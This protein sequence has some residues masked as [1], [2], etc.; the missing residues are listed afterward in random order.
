MESHDRCWL[1][2]QLKGRKEFALLKGTNHRRYLHAILFPRNGRLSLPNIDVV[3]NWY[4]TAA[5]RG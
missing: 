3:Y 1:N 2:D 5:N 4:N